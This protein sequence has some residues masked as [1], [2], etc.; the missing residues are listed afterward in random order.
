MISSARPMRLPGKSALVASESPE[1][2]SSAEQHLS[3]MGAQVRGISLLRWNEIAPS[4]SDHPPNHRVADTFPP[5]SG[6][7]V[8]ILHNRMPDP[9]EWSA[10]LSANVRQLVDAC[11]VARYGVIQHHVAALARARG[12]IVI[13]EQLNYA[14]SKTE[15][16][17][18]VSTGIVTGLAR[19]LTCE[20]S[21]MGIRVNGVVDEVSPSQRHLVSNDL[22]ETVIFLTTSESAAVSGTV[23][24]LEA[25]NGTTDGPE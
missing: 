20:L 22:L 9:S 25:P 12:A 17:P 24:R 18:R 16:W 10:S 7:D 1:F 21:R 3:R 19:A 4:S 11:S 6:L 8:L 2:L 14:S 23:L 13:V 15:P 5:A